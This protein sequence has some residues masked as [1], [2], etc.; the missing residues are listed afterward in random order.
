LK[1]QSLYQREDGSEPFT[2]WLNGLR[3]FKAQAR[4]RVRLKHLALGNLGDCESVGQGVLELRIH[5]G[6]GYRVYYA[7][8]GTGHGRSAAAHG[9]R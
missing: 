8:H 7:R 5:V 9:R 2:E 6:A 1:L 4:I 3:D